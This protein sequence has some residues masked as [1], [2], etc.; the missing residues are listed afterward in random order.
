MKKLLCTAV[1]LMLPINPVNG[2]NVL[3]NDQRHQPASFYLHHQN[4][5]IGG[6]PNN[7]DNI[8]MTGYRGININQPRQLGTINLYGFHDNDIE[9]ND[10]CTI[11]NIVND[12]S[13]NAQNIVTAANQNQPIQNGLNNHAQANIVFGATPRDSNHLITLKILSNQLDSIKSIQLKNTILQFDSPIT[14]NSSQ[15]KPPNGGSLMLSIV[16]A[17]VDKW[18]HKNLTKIS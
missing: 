17:S 9:I 3:V 13:Q 18:Y 14:V 16:A 15:D 6:I 5:W 1:I 10:N 12:T 8:F 11:T 4:D 7:G 2:A